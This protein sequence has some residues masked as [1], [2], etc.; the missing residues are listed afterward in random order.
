MTLTRR[1]FLKLGGISA[2]AASVTACG[3]L[4]RRLVE[5]DLP[6]SLQAPTP[7]PFDA[8][9]TA[10]A[11]GLPSFPANPALRLLNRAGYGP[12]PGD[13]ERVAQTGLAAYLEEQLQPETIDDQAADLIVRGLDL[14]HREIG[15]LLNQEPVDAGIALAQSTFYRALTSRRQL[16]EAMV[17]F[18]SDHFNIYLRKTQFMPFFK[19]VDDRDAIRPHALA[20]FPNILSASMHSAAMLIYLDNAQNRRGAPNENYARELLELHTLGVHGGYDQTDVQ[21]VARALTGWTVQRRGPHQGQVYLNP[22]EHDPAA[23]HLLGQTL[24]AH[25]GEADITQLVDILSSH[26]AA[27][28]FVATKLVRRLVAD[29]PPPAL[30][31]QAA[32]TF[33]GS[34]GDLKAILRLI[35]LSPE[36][37]AAPP[38]LKRPFAYIVSALRALHADV[39]DVRPLARWLEMMGQPLFQWAAPNGYPDVSPVWA[40]NLLPRWNF[41]V[42]LLLDQIRGVRV[43]FD[44]L[45]RAANVSTTAA[46]LEFF[47]GIT[48]N[49]P[50]DDD[51]RALFTDY[52]GSDHLN[53]RE[54]QLRLRESVALLLASPAFQWT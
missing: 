44:D 49:H 11:A 23:K 1:Q 8:P 2:V 48:L 20:S 41:A 51:A 15:D 39:S 54:I 19:I 12:R 40:S 37:A 38:K 3:A 5:N 50:L 53:N 47:A 13:L 27:A 52:I 31:Q 6:K 17:E 29:D 32:Q 46:A 36:F 9:T 34:G 25:Q 16:L 21:E 45:L 18:W 42:A 28:Q 33:Q 30:V 26:P 35:L 4:G 24:P 22:D 43:G 7:L 10:A 14:Y